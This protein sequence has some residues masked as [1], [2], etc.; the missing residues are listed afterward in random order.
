MSKGSKRRPTNE[1]IFSNNFDSIVWEF[2][3]SAP[4]TTEQTKK[5]E[6]SHA[7]PQ[8]CDISHNTH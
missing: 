6:D 3:E 8:K 7:E 1:H 5:H 2:E 4:D